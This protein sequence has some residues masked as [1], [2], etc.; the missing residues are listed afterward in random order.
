[1]VVEPGGKNGS[2]AGRERGA[3]AEKEDEFDEDER[4]TRYAGLKTPVGTKAGL[5]S[6]TETRQET[7]V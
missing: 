3:P 7:K 6:S 2:D 4:V 5:C 1:M